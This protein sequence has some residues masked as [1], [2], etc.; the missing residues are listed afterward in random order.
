[1]DKYDIIDNVSTL[2]A[3]QI[4][5]A[6]KNGIVT[7]DRIIGEA[8]PDFA[9]SKRKEVKKLL[10][11]GD[12]E[13]WTLAC[14]VNSK[15]SYMGY[16]ASFQAGK[17]R[18]EAREKI[19]IIDELEKKGLSLEQ[20]ENDW[21]NLNKKSLQAVQDYLS[22]YP[23]GVHA[24]EAN[25]LIKMI[26]LN[27]GK[28]TLVNK[29]QAI[30]TDKDLNAE[31]KNNNIIKEIE[32]YLKN[33]FITKY[34]LLDIIN[35][36]RN[37]F[38]A[39]LINRFI[40]EKKFFT[41]VDLMGLGIASGF[42][43]KMLEATPATTLIEAPHLESIYKQ[44]TEIY[45]WGIPSSGKSCALG[46]ILSVANNGTVAKALAQD[47][48]SQGYGYMKS[49]INLFQGHD[50]VTL[51]GGTRTDA[52]YEMGF[53]LYDFE[54]RIHPITCVDMAGEL[55]RC[56]YKS[57]A[58]MNLEDMELEMLDVLTKVLVDNVSSNRKIHIF[59]IEYGGEKRLYEGYPQ[60]IYLE[61]ATEYIK[62]TG[63]FNKA[64]DAIYVMITKADK[65]GHVP[66]AFFADYLQKNYLGFLNNLDIICKKNYI[67]GGKV[68]KLAFSLGEVCFQNFCKFNPAAAENVVRTILLGRTASEKTGKFGK[69]GRLFKG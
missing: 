2:S 18:D 1:M 22:K 49:L 64:T 67:N 11:G 19:R 28:T 34:D 54:D 35:R 42:V 10:E 46:A 65:A 62:N 16:L 13:A 38:N 41:F 32:T 51:M 29:C 47:T 12:D 59:V 57:N 25:E 37:F 61:G 68:E 20:E 6:I 15:E 56:M 9:P 63:I 69:L 50:I 45:F 60:S 44:S 33:E 17:H 43:S 14:Q 26:I 58:G 36:D 66:P 4:V 24:D 55:M 27:P 5:D 40:N 3:A 31:Q 21:L 52:F 8:G 48:G 30:M 39:G 23:D 53:D 7:Y